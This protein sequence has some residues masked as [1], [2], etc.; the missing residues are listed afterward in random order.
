MTNE[1]VVPKCESF[2]QFENMKDDCVSTYASTTA[3]APSPAVLDLLMDEEEAEATSQAVIAVLPEGVTSPPEGASSSKPLQQGIDDT[4]ALQDAMRPGAS[5]VVAEPRAS[6]TT[7]KAAKKLAKKTRTR[8]AFS[9]QEPMEQ[10]DNAS[11][12]QSAT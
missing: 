7:T 12:R 8:V 11:P 4:T 5:V 2:H 9:S 1:C 3:G 10:L 6:G